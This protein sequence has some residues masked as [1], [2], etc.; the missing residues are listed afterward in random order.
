M[1][2]WIP[3]LTNLLQQRLSS[4]G[5]KAVVAAPAEGGCA[6][7]IAHPLHTILVLTSSLWWAYGS[8]SRARVAHD[9]V[10]P[11]RIFLYGRTV[12]FELLLL[13]LVIAG[14]R[15]HGSPIQAVL[16][17]RWR[18][19]RAVMSDLGVGLAFWLVALIVTS[20][21][22]SVLEP[23]GN[24][25]AVQFLMPLGRAEMALWVLLSLTAGI[26]EE[27][28]YR[29]YLQR[30]LGAWTRSVPAGIV[31][32]AVAF[33]GVHLYQG[34][35]R[36]AVI[37]VGGVMGGLLAY[38]RKSVRPGMVAHAWQDAMAPVLMRLIKH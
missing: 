16:G 26:C 27:A 9:A 23:G 30:Q 6:E 21:L 36:A 22:G 33:G 3:G 25:R 17:E 24:N 37:W 8:A 31:L 18:S 29:G 12:V 5:E 7:S 1:I 2:S 13:A 34:W 20:A 32:S 38:W 11:N 10:N 35:H 4:M 14:V 19:A 28:V 15:W